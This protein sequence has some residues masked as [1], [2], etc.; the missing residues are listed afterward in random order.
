MSS[1]AASTNANLIQEIHGTVINLPGLG[2]HPDKTYVNFSL[3][4]IA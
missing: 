2:Q 4:D 3:H 1:P